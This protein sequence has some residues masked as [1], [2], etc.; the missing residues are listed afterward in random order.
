MSAAYLTDFK[1]RESYNMWHIF[2]SARENRIK[3]LLKYTQLEGKGYFFNTAKRIN[4]KSPKS[5]CCMKF[6]LWSSIHLGV[7][8]FC[9]VS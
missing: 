8:Y 4:D 1:I 9:S 5:K 6:L 2:F 7:G 3:F